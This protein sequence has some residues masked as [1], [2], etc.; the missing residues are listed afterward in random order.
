V[1]GVKLLEVAAFLIEGVPDGRLMV[2]VLV[3]AL[4]EFAG[5]AE[6]ITV[7]WSV[8]KCVRAAGAGEHGRGQHSAKG[9]GG[10]IAPTG[11]NASKE[12]HAG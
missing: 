9:H 11:K 8:G 6:S 12:Q 10:V 5:R 1:D 7:H 2:V 4:L 3:D